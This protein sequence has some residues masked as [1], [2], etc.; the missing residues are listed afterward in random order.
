M[1]NFL[2]TYGS[3]LPGLLLR[4]RALPLSPTAG[5]TAERLSAAV[6]FADISGS[7][8]LADR[9]ARQGS[10]GAEQLVQLLNCY[11]ERLIA[12]VTAHGGDIVK[13]AG[14][15]LL[16]CWT[17]QSPDDRLN[18]LCRRASQCGLAVQRE[19]HNYPVDEG[20]QLSLRV[21]IG[22]GRVL[23][24]SVGGL[25]DRW[26]FVMAGPPLVQMGIAQKQAETG[27]VSLAPEA[28]ELMQDHCCG[29]SASHGCMVLEDVFAPLPPTSY[30]SARPRPGREA[31]LRGYIPRSILP[32]LDAGH[33][34]WLAELRPVTVLFIKLDLVHDEKPQALERLHRATRALQNTLDHFGGTISGFGVDDKGTIMLAAF[35]LHGSTYVDNA[36]RAVRAALQIRSALRELGLDSAI[37]LATGRV[38]CGCVGSAGRRE[39]TMIGDIVNLAARLM[40]FAGDGPLCTAETFEAAR[41]HLPFQTLPRFVLKGKPHPVPVYRPLSATLDA[42]TPAPVV[43]REEAAATLRHHL[44]ALAQGESGVVFV[45]GEAGIG[46]SRLVAD[47]LQLASNRDVNAL[48]GEGDAIEAAMPYHAWR[49]VFSRFFG[50]DGLVSVAAQRRRVQKHLDSAPQHARRGPLL[51]AVLPLDIPENAFTRELTVREEVRADN[52]NELLVSLLQ[53]EAVRAPLLLVMEDAHWMDSASWTLAHLAARRVQPLLM[54]VVTRR[55]DDGVTAAGSQLAVA[56]GTE[57]LELEPLALEQTRELLRVLLGVSRLQEDLVRD[58]YRRAEGNPFFTEQLAFHLRDSGQIVVEK[59]AGRLEQCGQDDSALTLPDSIGTALLSRIDRLTPRQQMALKVASAIGRV[60][61][62]RLLKHV[63]LVE[64]DRAHLQD[65]LDELARLD[66][67]PV[68]ESASELAYR[69]KHTLTQEAAYSLLTHKD[70]RRVHR[71]IARW[72]METYPEDLSPYYSLLVHHWGRARDTRQ[73]NHFRVRSGKHALQTFANQ[74]AVALLTEALDRDAELGSDGGSEDRWEW[75]LLLGEAYVNW[76]KHDQGRIPLETGLRLGG[77]SVPAT[78]AGQVAGTLA[79]VVRLFSAGRRAAGDGRRVAQAREDLLRKSRAWERLAEVHYFA[80]RNEP[81]L[82]AALRALNLAEAAGCSPELARGYAALGALAGFIPLRGMAASFFSRAHQQVTELEESG[83][84]GHQS[85]AAFVSLAAGFYAAGLG[86][87][88]AAWRNCSRVVEISEDLGDRRS[89]DDGLSNL[90]FLHYF[91]GDFQRGAEVADRLIASALEREE[92]TT[93]SSALQGKAKIL[94][95]LEDPDAALSYLER[96]EALLTG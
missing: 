6:L 47:L 36:V 44:D 70:R 12:V 9:L 92:P 78:T 52:T 10:E 8:E 80:E 14:D 40:Q 35:G 90:L 64:S 25:N 76:Y 48:V 88:P 56:P 53:Q 17:A 75:Q 15:A 85:A 83:S 87:W 63:Y 96:A 79:E 91:Q 26:Q 82:Y 49:P 50:L 55:L 77:E 5:P 34:G 72:Y 89:R 51:N 84:P 95:C 81:A 22:A 86:D 1:P 59:G 60:F 23:L 29:R 20:L 67:T 61:P 24:A 71:D 39:Y 38:F 7:T 13:F 21:G 33:S 32:R 4:G 73:A 28:W 31:L 11:F 18:T 41:H 58:L 2:E 46:K 66:I 57:Q 16:A 74:E 62:H 19:L 27:K 3:F 45:Q 37:G 42:A 93:Q 69:F 94:L 43:G 68:E 30:G 65:T 54:V